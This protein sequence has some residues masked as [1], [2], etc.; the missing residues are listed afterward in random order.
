MYSGI[1]LSFRFNSRHHHSAKRF[2]P[3][4]QGREHE[5]PQD[6]A[7]KRL[8]VSEAPVGLVP[9][10]YPFLA[11]YPA[12]V[13]LASLTHVWKINQALADIPDDD[14]LTCYAVHHASGVVAHPVDLSL[15]PPDLVVLSESTVLTLTLPLN[16]V[17]PF[18]KAFQAFH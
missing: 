13:N 17:K 5:G 4:P 12:Q 11:L 3:P 18:P 1:S 14:A 9:E 10:V 2:P 15:H 6:K 16:V 8:A 7:L